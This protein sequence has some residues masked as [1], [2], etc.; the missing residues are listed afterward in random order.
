MQLGSASIVLRRTMI[1]IHFVPKC[2]FK[3]RFPSRLSPLHSPKTTRAFK[4]CES[5]VMDILR[6]ASLLCSLIT[7]TQRTTSSSAMA[8]CLH[9]VLHVRHQEAFISRLGLVG[10]WLID[11]S[12]A[13][14]YRTSVLSVLVKHLTLNRLPCAE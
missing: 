3:W 5:E 14:G 12:A 4:S 13:M 8:T 10:A 1:V 2:V 7:S 11:V 6:Y 9:Q